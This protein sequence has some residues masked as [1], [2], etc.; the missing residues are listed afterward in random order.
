V[1]FT[2]ENAVAIGK[3]G[4]R[5]KG[6][7]SRSKVLMRDLAEAVVTDLGV[8]NRIMADARAGTL[9]PGVLVAFFHYYAGRPPVKLEVVRTNLAREEMVARLRLLSREDRALYADLA[10]KMLAAP[11]PEP[12]APGTVIDVT[13][14]PAK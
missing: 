10:R 13:P 5:P 11:A 2:K 12:R 3:T 14:P 1:A 9:H 7:L 6:A 8:Q 4:G